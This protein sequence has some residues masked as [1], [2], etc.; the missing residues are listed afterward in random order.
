MAESE[1]GVDVF[2][3]ELRDSHGSRKGSAVEVREDE[4]AEFC[5]G[6]CA[7][8]SGRLSSHADDWAMGRR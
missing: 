1:A 4:L 3:P 7:V 2:V 5:H 6:Q 8:G